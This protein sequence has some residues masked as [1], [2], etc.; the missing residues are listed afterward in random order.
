M[1]GY[2]TPSADHHH[3][4]RFFRSL[5][6]AAPLLGAFRSGAKPPVRSRPS[7]QPRRQEE[8]GSPVASRILSCQS[9]ARLSKKAT[10][11]LRQA[12]LP[13]RYGPTN[14]PSTANATTQPHHWRTGGRSGAV[15]QERNDKIHTATT[16]HHGAPHPSCRHAFTGGSPQ[17]SVELADAALLLAPMRQ[18]HVQRADRFDTLEQSSGERT[19]RPSRSGV[20][21]GQRI[22]LTQ[23][24]CP[25]CSLPVLCQTNHLVFSI[26]LPE[27]PA[28]SCTL[29]VQ[30]TVSACL[31]ARTT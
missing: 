4:A 15:G 31:I 28:A 7:A 8:D 22:E 30:N 10:V 13:F 20:H 21:I 19:S 6:P 5:E 26:P 14:G 12:Y 18:W 23:F 16:R 1:P 3:G 9:G 25:F 2:S 27:P 24:G 11:P 17:A 29:K